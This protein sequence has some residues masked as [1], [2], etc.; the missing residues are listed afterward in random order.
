[1]KAL[2]NIQPSSAALAPVRQARR[3][4]LIDAAARCFL[5]LGYVGTTMEAVAAEAG[6]VVQTLYNSVGNKAALL[7]AVFEK[8][9]SGD[10]APQPV[11]VFMRQRVQAAPDLRA[12]IDRLSEWFLDANARMAPWWRIIDEAAAHDAEAAAFAQARAHRRLANY[13]HAAEELRRRRALRRGLG[14][15]EA[16]AIIWS[17]SH[18]QVYRTLVLEQKWTQ[19]RYRNWVADGLRAALTG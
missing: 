7:T 14:L 19:E 3:E 9:V 1:M 18:P 8:V 4:A 6:V 17:L 13:R 10:Q 12:V 16:A 15:E 2:K 5:R 11:P